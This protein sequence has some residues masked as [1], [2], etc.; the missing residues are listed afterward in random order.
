MT[1]LDQE[2]IKRIQEIVQNA[3]AEKRE[4]ILQQELSKLPKEQQEALQQPQQCPFCLMAENKIPTTN[5][6]EDNQFKAVLEINPA[7][8]GHILLF[9]KQHFSDTTKLNQETTK[10]LFNIANNLAKALQKPTNIYV[11]NGKEAGQRFDHATIHIIPRQENDKVNFVWQPQKV[12]QEELEKIKQ[13]IVSN[14]PQKIEVIPEEPSDD[15][16]PVSPETRIP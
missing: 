6:Y 12:E 11:S 15:I 9:T 3:P 4:E 16:T 8:P 14:L 2:T 7:N 10:E 1:N 5:L 13:E